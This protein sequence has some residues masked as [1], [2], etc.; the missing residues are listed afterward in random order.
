MRAGTPVGNHFRS[1]DLLP[2][3]DDVKIIAKSVRSIYHLMTL[4]ALCIKAIKPAINT[5]DE[6]KSRTLVIKI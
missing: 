1:C 2:T 6:F 3:M 4:E 5:K